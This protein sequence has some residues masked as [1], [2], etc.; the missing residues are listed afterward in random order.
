[1]KILNI[2]Y[3]TVLLVS[4]V[5]S[6]PIFDDTENNTTLVTVN[7][8][9]GDVVSSQGFELGKLAKGK[10]GKVG[11]VGKKI[12]AKAARKSLIVQLKIVAKSLKIIE[13]IK[14]DTNED[15]LN[16][17]DEVTEKLLTE[18][19]VGLKN[20]GFI[21]PI[22]QFSLTDDQIRQSL[23]DFTIQLLQA[24]VI[25]WKDILKALEES[26]LATDVLK[27]ALTDPETRQGEIDLILE[28]L[29]QLLEE[30]V[31]DWKKLLATLLEHIPKH[32]GLQELWEM[33]IGHLLQHTDKKHLWD[34]IVKHIPFNNTTSTFGY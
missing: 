21:N 16:V 5:T 1:M 30:A 9:N 24:H 26:G 28:L 31:I 15:L 6:T 22:L 12:G 23:I 7:Q 2:I 18:I 25:P 3:V 17:F 14:Q 27:F 20:S 13:G 10:L 29:P 8:Y 33:I 11:K 32:I 34:T 4:G 19:F